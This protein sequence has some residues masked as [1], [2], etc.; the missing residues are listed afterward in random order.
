MKK[1]F[2]KWSSEEVNFIDQGFT[3]NQRGY[4][5]Y[6]QFRQPPPQQG[7]FQERPPYNFGFNQSQNQYLSDSYQDQPQR[8]TSMN[9]RDIEVAK[10]LDLIMERL[11]NYEEK[12]KLQA[13]INQEHEARGQRMK[14]MI[15]NMVSLITSSPLLNQ[16]SVQVDSTIRKEHVKAVSTRS[17]KQSA[18]PAAPEPAIIPDAIAIDKPEIEEEDK[19]EEEEVTAS[20]LITKTSPAPPLPPYQP[21]IPFPKDAQSQEKDHDTRY[22]KWHG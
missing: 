10:T 22:R 2:G 20:P 3:N 5:D 1:I 15:N 11:D 18:D 19:E 17:D 8:S 12:F 13:V 14:S 16:P 9:T 7:S 4:P 21:Q 6:R